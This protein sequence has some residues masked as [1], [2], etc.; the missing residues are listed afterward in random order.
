MSSH[1]QFDED[2]DLQALGAL[3]GDES[4]ALELHLA[5][6]DPC[7]ERADEAR[8]RMALLAVA[9]PPLAPPPEV[10]DRLMRRIRLRAVLGGAPRPAGWLRWVTPALALA[11]L[12]LAVTTGVLWK[13]NSRLEHSTQELE[14]AAKQQA[15]E[16]ERARAV[17]EVLTSPET[18][19]VALVPS[20]ARPVPQGRA[21]YHAA[22]GRLLFSA[23]NLPALP[24]GRA[25]EL[26]LIPIQ[27]DPIAAGVFQPDAKGNGEVLLPSLEAGV[28]AKAFAVTVEP[29]GGV[30]KPTGSMVM[31]GPVS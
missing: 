10:R 9:A 25:Y 18:I 13:Q 4:D 22:K 14:S 6:C 31:V 26:W 7:R 23:V 16:M 20:G 8:G 3:E 21:L 24:A 28:K 11:A 1:P 29:A 30:P 5:H 19:K 27:G 2:F 15:T 17:L 12:V